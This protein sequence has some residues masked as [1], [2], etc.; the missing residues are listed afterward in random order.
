MGKRPHWGEPWRRL[1][2]TWDKLEG[3][4]KDK[5]EGLT[6]EESEDS[7][8]DKLEG[9]TRDKSAIEEKGLYK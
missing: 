3:P 9:L 2:P 7:T 1:S 4:T 6:K 8:K 5:L